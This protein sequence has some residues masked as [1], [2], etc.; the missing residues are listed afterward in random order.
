MQMYYG[1]SI[2][3]F[4]ASDTHCIKW[5]SAEIPKA[6]THSTVLWHILQFICLDFVMWCVYV[7]GTV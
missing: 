4:P 5:N 7:T 3:I 6:V 1:V 2:A